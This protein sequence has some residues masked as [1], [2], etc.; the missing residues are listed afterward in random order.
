MST[1][2]LFRWLEKHIKTDIHYLAHG[3]FW[4]LTERVASILLTLIL[5]IAFGNLLT[6]S[7][8][9]IYKYVL[10]TA[11]IINAFSLSGIGNII[12][13]SSARNL[14]KMFLTGVRRYFTFSIVAVLL[15]IVFS[16]YYFSQENYLLGASFMLATIAMPCIKG[17]GFYVNFLQG[18]KL[19]KTRSKFLILRE[20]LFVGI[21]VLMIL[22]VK[23][24][25][26]IIA[27][28]FVSQ[29]I[30]T[31]SGY[32]AVRKMLTNEK[33]DVSLFNFGNHISLMQLLTTVATQAD[34]VLIFLLL[35]PTQL[36]IYAFAL[37]PVEKMLQLNMVLS[38]LSLP[39]FSNRELK[40]IKKNILYKL[41]LLTFLMLCL[42]IS[43]ITLAPTLFALVLPAYQEAVFY[44]QILSLLLLS[45][46]FVLITTMF[47]AHQKTRELYILNSIEP[48]TRIILMLILLPLYGVWG[49]ISALLI[50]KLIQVLTG[51]ATIRP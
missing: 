33:E 1:G 24:I 19:F 25:S 51:I 13:Q 2:T 22:Y 47:Q 18:K 30:F 27:T 4:L 17:F 41:V 21:M 37:L 34:K 45:V 46:P 44:S 8:Y 20:A 15:G 28:Y 39:R 42:V 35:G 43:Y 49:I 10:A 29:A 26:L 5:G 6:P 31:F 23:D 14:D 50:A 38:S 16:L 3:G 36:A 11:I 40:D 48:A 12:E 9:G 32:L 7:D